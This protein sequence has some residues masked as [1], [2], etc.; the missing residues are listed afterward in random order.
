MAIDQ[1]GNVYFAGA[2]SSDPNSTDGPV[3]VKYDNKGNKLWE[4]AYQGPAANGWGMCTAIT[5]DDHGN[6]YVTGHTMLRQRKYEFDDT[7]F[8][9]MTIKYDSNGKQLW[10]AIYSEPQKVL[11][12]ADAIAVDGAGNVYV[13]AESYLTD[14]RLDPN[15]PEKIEYIPDWEPDSDIVIIKYDANGKQ[16]WA[17]RYGDDPN[18]LASFCGLAVGRDGSVC[19]T[20]S[21]TIDR[22]MNGM[23]FYATTIKY[24]M[25]GKQQWLARFSGEPNT[26]TSPDALAV[27]GE[28][29]VYVAASSSSHHGIDYAD[30]VTIKYDTNGRQQWLAR[31]RIT[32]KMSAFP[33]AITVDTA[34]NV[35][36]TGWIMPRTTGPGYPP[37]DLPSALKRS[38]IA[39][40]KYDA[41]GKE[42]WVKTYKES[43]RG[44]FA[45][46][47]IIDTK[48]DIYVIGE[49]ALVIKYDALGNQEWAGWFKNAAELAKFLGSL[50]R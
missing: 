40:L 16:L 42:L 24:N 7:V 11:T 49:H 39:T 20:G 3:T 41:N 43:E 28:G 18:H 14:K 17:V 25:H 26:T 19:I 30:F 38:Q 15:D 10:S 27:D 1:A 31:H 33:S 21:S 50:K 46:D 5:A 4:Q 44:V 32:G 29:N 35:C 12:S 8:G 47:L 6:A 22:G 48:G 23:D 13:A 36:V 45:R 37:R 34:R 2:P 9:Y